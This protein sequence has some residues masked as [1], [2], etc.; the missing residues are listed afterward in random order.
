MRVILKNKIVRD[1]FLD[2]GEGRVSSSIRPLI[3]VGVAA[4]RLMPV[5]E[6]ERSVV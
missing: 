6:A 3:L 5:V 4:R 1:R 2:E